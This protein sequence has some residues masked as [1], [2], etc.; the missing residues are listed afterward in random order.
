MTRSSKKSAT[1][2]N[3][4]PAKIAPGTKRHKRRS[5][6]FQ[7][8]Q[9]EDAEIGKKKRA[10]AAR[11]R[12]PATAGLVSADGYTKDILCFAEDAPL[13][14]MAPDLRIA[15]ETCVEQLKCPNP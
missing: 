12:K 5:D 9:H 11:R 13:V 15:L 3:A 10:A 7:K 14:R 1:K 8:M 6:K 2:S 4:R